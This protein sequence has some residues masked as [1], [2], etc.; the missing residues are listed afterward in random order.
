[1]SALGG[2]LDRL[3]HRRVAGKVG[4]D[5]ADS[6][7]ALGKSQAF[8]LSGDPVRFRFAQSTLWS[9]VAGF[10]GAGFIAGL[11]F[12]LFE[13]RWYIHIGG[14]NHQIF[15]LKTW[16]DGGM[17][18]IHSANW[19]LYRHTAFRDIPEPAFATMAITTLLAKK[20]W[21]GVRV[22]TW[23]IL[24][25]PLV[26]IGLTLALGVLGVW[27]IDFA[28]PGAWAHAA[29]AF[30][31]PGFKVSAHFLGK[32]SVPQLLLGF[33]IGR[34][35]HRYWAPVGATLQGYQ[36]DR[37]VDYWQGKVEAAQISTDEAVRL[38]N[39][40]LHILPAWVR[41]PIMPPVIRERFSD[42]WRKNVSINIRKSH[43]GVVMTMTV[44]VVL[45]T[46]LG[47]LGHYWVGAGHT[48][49]YIAPGT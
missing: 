17:G 12:G 16:W 6:I 49:P 29:T 34:I 28:L 32:L 8:L 3:P 26:I 19:P 48:I 15:Y 4:S 13:V 25:A 38:N 11:Y 20:K 39:A 44:V 35:L 7:T 21:W 46:L 40:G 22:G 14:F 47:L 30:R 45:V 23:R 24:T 37:T 43:A 18:F 5:V 36:L 10:I 42:M 2:V 9:V 31:H 27:L 1:M 33:L 41:L